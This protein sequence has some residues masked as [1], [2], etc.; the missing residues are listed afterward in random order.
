M[1]RLKFLGK[2]IT[3][4]DWATSILHIG[5]YTR[6]TK[7]K[8]GMEIMNMIEM[9]LVKRDI[10]KCMQ[11]SKMNETRTLRSVSCIM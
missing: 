9:L 11:D 7:D 6:V 1:V 2:M 8:D 3:K 10:L 5:K 4:G